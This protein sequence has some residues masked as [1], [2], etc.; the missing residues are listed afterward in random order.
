MK[1]NKIIYII[2]MIVLIVAV[3]ILVFIFVDKAK[4]DKLGEELREEH[5]V[6]TTAPIETEVTTTPPETETEVVT[7]PLVILPEMEKLLEKNS[8]TAGWITVDGTNIDNIILQTTDNEYYLSKDFN[9]EYSIGGSIYFDYRSNINDMDRYLSNNIII[10]GHNQADGTMFGTL[11]KYKITHANTSNFEFYKEH[12]TF[13]FSNLY[14][15]YTCKIFA[16]FVTEASPEQIPDGN[17]FDYHNYINYND[18]Y[19]FE[20]FMKNL[21]ERSAINTG[22]DVNED[23]KL[24][25]LS[26]CSNEF[27]NSRFVIVARCLREGEDPS[28]DTS[29]VT[30]NEDAKEPDYN[31]IYNK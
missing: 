24:V 18:N 9:K 3:G 22:I 14:E 7:E 25:T 15:N 28:V 4:A 12:P 17:F 5:S 21:N 23:D 8:D 1:N 26:T 29:K 11:K 13:T 2:A 19:T 31:F 20:N 30:I 6:T 16:M 27:D 10:Y